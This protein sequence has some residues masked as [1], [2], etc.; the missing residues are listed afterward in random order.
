MGDVDIFENQT[1]KVAKFIAV[2]A[3]KIEEESLK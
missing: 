2:Y 1:A 3:K